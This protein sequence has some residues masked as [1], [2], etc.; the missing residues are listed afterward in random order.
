MVEIIDLTGEV[1][2]LTVLQETE[3]MEIDKSS[4][5]LTEDEDLS[6]AETFISPEQFIQLMKEEDETQ[7]KAEAT[8]GATPFICLEVD[9]LGDSSRFLLP[10]T[11]EVTFFNLSLR[12]KH[13]GFVAGDSLYDVFSDFPS[14]DTLGRI[15]V[16]ASGSVAV[17]ALGSTNE[18]VF[19]S[20]NA[21]FGYNVGD[22]QPMYTGDSQQYPINGK[23]VWFFPRNS[24]KIRF[25]V[26]HFKYANLNYANHH[27]GSL[28][29]FFPNNRSSKGATGIDITNCDIADLHGG[30]YT[31]EW[32]T[33]YIGNRV[34]RGLGGFSNDI[35]SDFD[36]AIFMKRRNIENL[37]ELYDRLI[38]MEREPDSD[39]ESD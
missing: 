5:D 14:E 28:D 13:E 32:L 6:Q 21:D 19:Y 24:L 12:G 37:D 27:H 18:K 9:G 2:D 3:E 4:I 38:S 7:E 8:P 34:V 25:F 36:L 29:Y 15:E 10:L 20:C 31:M 33:P 17:T 16:S 23:C 22:L 1:I 11:K 26:S 30:E 39:S 35:A